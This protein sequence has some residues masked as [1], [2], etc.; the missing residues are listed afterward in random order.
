VPSSLVFCWHCLGPS[1]LFKWTE[2]F[3]VFLSDALG[4]NT[5]LCGVGRAKMAAPEEVEV[6]VEEMVTVPYTPVQPNV[7]FR[8]GCGVELTDEYL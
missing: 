3:L 7:T 1:K 2:V 6:K 4:C 8:C 5:A